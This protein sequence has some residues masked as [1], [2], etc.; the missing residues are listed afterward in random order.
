MISRVQNWAIEFLVIGVFAVFT[1]GQASEERS[2]EIY[3]V[4]S[5]SSGAPVD[6]ATIKAMH[7]KKTFL[8]HC[9]LTKMAPIL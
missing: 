8:L 3:G 5:G 1:N 6:Q 7:N 4:V 2:S 9:T